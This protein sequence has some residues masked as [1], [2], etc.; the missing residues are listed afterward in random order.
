MI[1]Q[2]EHEHFL[3]NKLFELFFL[4]MIFLKNSLKRKIAF[5]GTIM[6]S[7]NGTKAL[8]F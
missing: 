4:S 5:G 7:Q 6:S 1:L 2:T 8:F 3:L